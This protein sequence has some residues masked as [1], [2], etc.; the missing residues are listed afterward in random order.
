MSETILTL[1]APA[2]DM[3]IRYGADLNQF[4]DLRLP[5]TD[6]PHPLA[7]NI[8]GGF[9]R[10]KYDLAHA[11]HLCAALTAKGIATANLE[12]RRAGNE[13]GGWPGTFD[14]IRAALRYLQQNAPKGIESNRVIVMGHSA[15]GELA[16]ALAAHEPLVRG[17]IS[18]AGVLDLRRT[19]DLHLSN[20][21]VAEF[22]GGS[23]A[24]VPDHYREAD[25][26]SL[27]VTKTTAQWIIHG[28]K[29]DV[30]PPDFSHKYAEKKKV[31]GENVHLVEIEG[32][33]HFDLI[34]PRSAA[35]PEVEKAALAA[36]S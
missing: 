7:I 9:W 26:M 13:G 12:Y 6:G 15:G 27:H 4:A 24:E 34:D 29:D 36:C 16:V 35:W 18:L 3:R 11:G 28:T 22:L 23:P 10:A 33:D 32:V 2:A 20:G 1:A 31:A 21:A 30:V 19:F 14:D 17:V 5:K 25:P 8:H